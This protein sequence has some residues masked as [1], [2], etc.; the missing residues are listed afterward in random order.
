MSRWAL[1]YITIQGPVLFVS[2]KKDFIA[3]AE[4]FFGE[5][6]GFTLWRRCVKMVHHPILKKNG[7]YDKMESIIKDYIRKEARSLA[8]YMGLMAALLVYLILYTG[9][10]LLALLI[11]PLLV[12][13]FLF[14][15]RGQAENAFQRCCGEYPESWKRQV[16][17]EYR[18]P[19]PVCKVA[20]GEVHLMKTCVVCRNK[21]RLIFIP[22]RQVMK[23]EER[24]RRVS[25]KR[26]PLLKFTLD[27]GT[28]LELDFSVAHTKDGDKVVSWFIE[29]IGAQKVERSGETILR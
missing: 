20:Y 12:A 22:V 15:M 3:G 17:E 6:A 8:L 16:E 26:V 21:R 24:F 29:Q 2:G 25:G 9:M 13:A 4:N 10:T 7:V 1:S 23:L 18:Q 11:I 5:A 19:H 14:R 28:E 27:G